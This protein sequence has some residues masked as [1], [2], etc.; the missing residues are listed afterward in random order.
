MVRHTP[1]VMHLIPELALT[2][3]EI[4]Y[5]KL[6]SPLLL[7]G[8]P[9]EEYELVLVLHDA[10]ALLFLRCRMRG[11]G[12]MNLLEMRA[13]SG[14]LGESEGGRSLVATGAGPR[15]TRSVLS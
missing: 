11:A 9:S 2:L 1:G 5:V 10:A 14:A 12:V 3:F 4:E 15:H 8:V 6:I 7:T 13:D